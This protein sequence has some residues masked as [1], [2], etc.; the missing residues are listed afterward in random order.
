MV[1]NFLSSK[2][3][4]TFFLWILKFVYIK[5]LL[6]EGTLTG[7]M[8]FI[9][10]P[11]FY[12]KLIRMERDF[13]ERNER[14]DS[15]LSSTTALMNFGSDDENII[16]RYDYPRT[17]DSYGTFDKQRKPFAANLNWPFCL[18]N[19]SILCVTVVIFGLI[20]TITS[21]Y[22]NLMTVPDF[23]GFRSPCINILSIIWWNSG[24][25]AFNII[26]II[27]MS[28]MQFLKMKWN[29]TNQMKKKNE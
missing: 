15:N 11:L 6:N 22:F 12:R 13:D 7:P 21:T 17:T 1:H 24:W 9:L 16:T 18:C 5:N 29:Q 27:V 4:I 10:P 25:I 2:I 3:L 19:D 23:D 28:K 8:I 14:L 26:I 20:V